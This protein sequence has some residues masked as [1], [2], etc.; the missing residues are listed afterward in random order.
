MAHRQVHG[1]EAARRFADHCA[2]TAAGVALIDERHELVRDMVLVVADRRAVHVLASAES[3][4][5]VRQDQ[6]R[7]SAALLR[8]GLV[9]FADGSLMLAPKAKVGYLSDVLTV[10]MSL[11]MAEKQ[12]IFEILDQEWR[13]TAVLS[14]LNEHLD[15]R[16]NFSGEQGDPDLN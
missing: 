15:T 7:R 13:A 12:K 6:D 10:A 9:D 1:P 2:A 4:E 3:R 5:A 8:D 14:H 16:Q 11:D